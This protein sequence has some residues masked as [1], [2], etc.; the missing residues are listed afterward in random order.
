MD[1]VQK[2]SNTTLRAPIGTRL[3]DAVEKEKAA[4]D[5]EMQ[6]LEK[7]LAILSDTISRLEAKL[8]PVLSSE[9]VATGPETARDS[10]G[11][12]TLCRLLYEYNGSLEIHT[13]RINHTISR[14]EV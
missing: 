10:Y 2:T 6:R 9:A 1:D 14:V 5:E 12:S 8:D 4:I 13:N 7:N 3:T 11:S